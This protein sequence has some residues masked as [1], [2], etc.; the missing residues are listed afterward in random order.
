MKK[1]KGKEKGNGGGGGADQWHRIADHQQG[2]ATT[3]RSSPGRAS[4]P[5]HGLVHF[6]AA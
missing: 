1:K 3:V 4:P 2:R 5:S 6:N